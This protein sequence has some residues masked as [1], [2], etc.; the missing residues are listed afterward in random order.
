MSLTTHEGYYAD[1]KGRM[2]QAKKHSQDQVEMSYNLVNMLHSPANF[3]RKFHVFYSCCE[4]YLMPLVIPIYI[5]TSIL[6]DAFEV[7]PRSTLDIDGRAFFI[8]NNAN[9]VILLIVLG[10]FELLKTRASRQLYQIETM[11]IFYAL[12]NPILQLPVVIVFGFGPMVWAS[13][14]LLTDRIIFNVTQKK[15]LTN[16]T[17]DTLTPGSESIFASE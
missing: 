15:S 4:V 8:F 10:L 9:T 3:L 2:D 7:L 5:L 16:K 12:Q 17:N 6:Q 13:Y 11:G 14:S 1:F